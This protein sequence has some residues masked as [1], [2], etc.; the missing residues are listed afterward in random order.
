MQLYPELVKLRD[1]LNRWLTPKYGE[2]LYIDFDFSAIPELQEDMDK[3]VAQ[4]GPSLV[5]NS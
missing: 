4:L 5:G 2:N 3:M 1:E